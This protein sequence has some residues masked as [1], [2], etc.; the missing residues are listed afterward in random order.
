[1]QTDQGCGAN[2][3][4][5]GFTHLV[6]VKP[7]AVVAGCRVA[8]WALANVVDDMKALR[9]ASADHLWAYFEAINVNVPLIYLQ[10]EYGAGSYYDGSVN[11]ATGTQYYI[12]IVRDETI[13]NG[14]LTLYIYSNAARTSLVDTLS[15][16]LHAK[17][18][19]QFITPPPVTTMQMPIPLASSGQPRPR[20]AIRRPL[21]YWRRQ[22]E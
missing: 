7:T 18:D 22:Q 6:D 12:K 14:T 4:A 13:G 1:V 9:V 16:A 20:R 15:V 11:L 3:F 17:V 21:I 10:E 5:A 2:H 19:F 8:W